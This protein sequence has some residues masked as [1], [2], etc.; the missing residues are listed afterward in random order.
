MKT[1]I[2]TKHGDTGQTALAGG[3]RVSKSSI[4]V[5]AY[6]TIDE[7]NSCLGFARSICADREIC[8]TTRQIQK[9]LFHIG[10]ALATPPSFRKNDPPMTEQMVDALTSQVH[11]IEAIEGVLSDWSIPGEHSAAAA[12]DVGRTVCRRAER[13]VIRMIEAG[14]ETSPFVV[15]YL[16]RLS[17]L[18][19]LFGR[20]LE[21]RAGL[22]AA[23]RDEQH[24]GPRWSRAWGDVRS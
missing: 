2:A 4:R 17:D 3:V 14:E 5:E 10:S 9:E 16:N 1:R 12:Y 8:D 19:W 20:L 23:L 15:P 7:L 13:R 11:K 6:G 24:N 18:Q 21:Y 22:N